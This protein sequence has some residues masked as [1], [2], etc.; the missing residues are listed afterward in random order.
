M[1]LVLALALAP[2]IA[3][4][5]ESTDPDAPDTGPDSGI[6]AAGEVPAASAALFSYLTAGEYLGYDAE[7]GVHTSAGPHGSGVRTYLD[8]LLAD[9]LAAGNRE[10][11]V[12]AAAIKELYAGDGSTV[13]GWAVMVK[14]AAGTA[15]NTWFFY[16]VFSTTDGSD[17]IEGTGLS[18][19][20]GCHSAGTDF[21][22]VGYP[23][24]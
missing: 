2:V 23:L 14:T 15:G 4:A 17:P 18:I 11:P 8:P 13:S 16:E 3:C 9:S 1:R 22:R 24:Q 5:S 19:C 6:E 21:V 7:S 20:T 10:H 12:G